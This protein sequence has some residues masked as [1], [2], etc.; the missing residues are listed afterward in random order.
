MIKRDDLIT[1]IEKT[2]GEDLISKARLKDIYSNGVQIHGK[3]EV[4]KIALGVSLTHDFLTESVASGADFC[5]THHGLDLTNH[6][7]VSSRI[8][9]GLQRDLKYIID[10]DLTVAGYHYALDAHKTMG[11]NAVLIKELGAAMTGE[12]YYGEWGYVAEFKKPMLATELATKL[13][14]LT[15][16][17]V[18]SVYGGPEMVTRIGVCTGG[19]KP[20]D[21]E[22][23]EIIDKKIDA[24]IAG[25]IIEPSIAQAK[26]V[27]F[28]YFAC[29][30]YATEVFGVQE[31]GKVIKSHFGNKLE[32]EFIDIPN[33]L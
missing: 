9:A 20:Y 32:V 21:R 19:A 10:N 17:D 6:N 3:N 15:S 26:G 31:L 22:L 23:F 16:H 7:I 14:D 33:S 13:A 12:T 28:N 8:H 2:I 24:H 29:G 4:N 11:N 27:G 1:F 30:H 5:L 25:E 18:F